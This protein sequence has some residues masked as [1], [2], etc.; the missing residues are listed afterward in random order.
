MPETGG[1]GFADGRHRLELGD[2]DEHDA[3][4]WPTSALCGSTHGTDCG[5]RLIADRRW[6]LR[7][8]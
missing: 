3:G 4:R 2:R 5:Q 8:S 7:P 1:M 6:I